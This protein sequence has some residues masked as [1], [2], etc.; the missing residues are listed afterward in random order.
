MQMSFMGCPP[1]LLLHP[2]CKRHLWVVPQLMLNS[3]GLL[4]LI[5]EDGAED[6]LGRNL[7]FDVQKIGS[8]GSPSTYVTSPIHATYHQILA[9]P[10]V[11]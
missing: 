5:E 2:P 7:I 10:D 4:T 8:F 3:V 11:P 6:E 1:C 9:T